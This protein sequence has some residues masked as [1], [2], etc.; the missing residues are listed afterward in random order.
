MCMSVSQY[1]YSLIEKVLF[2]SNKFRNDGCIKDVPEQSSFVKEM[3]KL[4][5]RQSVID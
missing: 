2:Y 3:Y 4:F 5:M 1:S